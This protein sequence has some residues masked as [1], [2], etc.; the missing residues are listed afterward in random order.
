MVTPDTCPRWFC[1]LP[2][3]KFVYINKTID[4]KYKPWIK[5]M[6]KPWHHK[7][8]REIV[9]IL[10]IDYYKIKNRLIKLDVTLIDICVQK[11]SWRG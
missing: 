9:A 5:P 8:A 11:T 7:S 3:R 1:A 10:K 4:N 6:S 2:F